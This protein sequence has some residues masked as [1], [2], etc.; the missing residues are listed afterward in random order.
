MQRGESEEMIKFLNWLARQG[1]E[2]N[3]F[4]ELARFLAADR[5]KGR[6]RKQPIANHLR[7]DHYQRYLD[8]ER[9]HKQWR[10]DQ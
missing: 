1:F 7:K 8:F 10:Q 4:G 5:C 2:N 6:P 9:L 3:E